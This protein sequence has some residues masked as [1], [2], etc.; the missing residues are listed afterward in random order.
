[1]HLGPHD[2]Y[3][4]QLEAL[5][6]ERREAPR[7]EVANL[8][9]PGTNSTQVLD[10]L[11]HAMTV[12]APDVVLLM[13]G[14]NDLWTERFVEGEEHSPA[15]WRRHSRLYRLYLLLR[16]TPLPEI[17]RS[18]ETSED[19][20]WIRLGD[21]QFERRFTRRGPGVSPSQVEAD[22]VTLVE[23][24]RG[25]RAEV[26]LMT[27]P[28]RTRLYEIANPIVR[29][30]ARRSDAPLIDLERRFLAA[31][32]VEPCP[33]LLFEDNHPTR[34]GYGIVARE[35]EARLAAEWRLTP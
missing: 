29:A 7:L 33:D 12:V 27:Y 11:D 20:G 31:C 13:V 17:D 5:W 9:F 34:K 23:R 4:A 10:D 16:R 19:S 21:E 3:P 2:A 28:A 32:P 26:F 24:I 8:G 6:N 25:W 18:F 14:V 30:A 35:I 15:W 22:L 1:L